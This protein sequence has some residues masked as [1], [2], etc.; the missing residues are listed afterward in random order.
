V[1]ALVTTDR[2]TQ[3]TSAVWTGLCRRLGI[4]QLYTTAYHP[5][6]NG[7]V[8][9]AHRQIKDALRSRQAGSSWRN[10]SL[11]SSWGSGH[12]RKMTAQY[13]RRSWRMGSL[14]FYPASC[15][16][17]TAIWSPPW[18][19]RRSNSHHYP[20][21]SCPMPKRRPEHRRL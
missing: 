14:L 1:P 9:R 13:H 5:Q 17:K 8:E 11:G 18:S 20:H 10:T 12:R 15:L 4:T 19:R 2:G 7:M 3:F 16:T 21:G 6:A